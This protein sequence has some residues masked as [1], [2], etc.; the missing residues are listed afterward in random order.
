VIGGDIDPIATVADLEELAAG[1]DGAQLAIIAGAGH[2]T[3]RDYPEATL[4]RLQAFVREV[5]DLPDA[6]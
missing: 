4:G 1:I 5:G 6:G 2:S 3:F